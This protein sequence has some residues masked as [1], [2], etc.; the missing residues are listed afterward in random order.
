MKVVILRVKLDR[1]AILKRLDYYVS[2]ELKNFLNDN[3]GK[4]FTAEKQLE[5]G[6]LKLYTLKEDNHSPKYVFY[7]KDFIVLEDN[8]K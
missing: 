7:E 2:I 8:D 4:V 3:E 1:N 5:Y 6:F